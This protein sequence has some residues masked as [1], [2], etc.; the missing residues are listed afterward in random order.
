MV[1]DDCSTDSSVNYLREHF[2][3]IVV[4]QNTA[5]SGFAKTINKGIFAAKLSHLLLLNSDV[6]LTKEYFLP[7][8]RYFDRPDT[9]GVM[10]RIIGWEDEQIQDAGKYPFFH[11]VKIKTSRNYVPLHPRHDNWL[12]TMYLSG[13]NAFVDRE[14]IMQLKGLDEIFSPFYVEDYE[15]S[16]RA[17]RLGWKCYYEH[18]SICRH[19]IS[20][21]IRSTREKKAVAVIYNRNK[22][23]LHAIHL[24][25]ISKFL[26][27]LQLLAELLLRT[28]TFQFYYLRSFY[29]FLRAGHRVAVSQKAFSALAKSLQRNIS[30]IQVTKNIKYALRSQPKY[31]L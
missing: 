12:Y 9:F 14:K 20:S 3:E 30:V 13:A 11:G 8:L 4:L 22:M 10:G 23:Y 16:L 17:W 28:L 15:L 29:L 18:F 7:L 21:T 24:R 25:G 1:V 6:K 27:Y 2:K 5:N 26:W 31:W 19:K